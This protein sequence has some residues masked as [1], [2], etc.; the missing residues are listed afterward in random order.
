[1]LLLVMGLQGYNKHSLVLYIIKFY[2]DVD[3]GNVFA[4]FDVLQFVFRSP[5]Y[6]DVLLTGM[7]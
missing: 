4:Q 1:M 6:K 2:A 3:G 7:G 5:W